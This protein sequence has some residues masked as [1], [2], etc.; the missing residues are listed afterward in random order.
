MIT[1]AETT[2]NATPED[3][4]FA[5]EIKANYP[6]LVLRQLLERMD[7][8]QQD[9]GEHSDENYGFLEDAWEE[10]A[11]EAS[12]NNRVPLDEVDLFPQVARCFRKRMEETHASCEFSDWDPE[13]ISEEMRVLASDR[14]KVF[15]EYK[16]YEHA[17]E[18]WA[19]L[20]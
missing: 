12:R 4:S 18:L 10:A 14:A 7:E 17:Q 6:D 20:V 15:L 19:E 16:V 3:R 5:Y 8:E 9:W 11:E 13:L 1:A 2:T